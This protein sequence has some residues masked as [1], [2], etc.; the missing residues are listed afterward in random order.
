MNH[1]HGHLSPGEQAAQISGLLLLSWG[2]P[3]GNGSPTG[4][5]HY[6]HQEV[7]TGPLGRWISC[8]FPP[9]AAEFP[10]ILTNSV[11]IIHPNPFDTHR[12]HH[13]LS[14][15]YSRMFLYTLS[16]GWLDAVVKYVSPSQGNPGSQICAHPSVEME[17]EA[18]KGIW[19]K[20]IDS[21]NRNSP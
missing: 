18:R 1:L 8:P 14:I 7:S 5:Q 16:Q 20:N 6:K 13:N 3:E 10:S 17:M 2:L 21:N 19:A 9:R 4:K 11:M 12:L 15:C